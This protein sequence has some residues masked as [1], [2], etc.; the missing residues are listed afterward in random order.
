[1]ATVGMGFSV[2]QDADVQAYEQLRATVLA[3]E[4]LRRDAARGARGRELRRLKLSLKEDGKRG[5]SGGVLRRLGSLC[6]RGLGWRNAVSVGGVIVAAKK[7]EEDSD[8]EGEGEGEEEEGL[9][10][11]EE[12]DIKVALKE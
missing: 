5:A 12:V 10:G 4:R 9:L 2:E 6:G 3:Q 7:L 11:F 1:M 8:F